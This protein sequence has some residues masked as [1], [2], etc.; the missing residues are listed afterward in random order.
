MLFGEKT[1]KLSTINSKC[2][3]WDN[4]LFRCLLPKFEFQKTPKIMPQKMYIYKAAPYIRRTKERGGSI[5]AIQLQGQIVQHTF[6]SFSCHSCII[7]I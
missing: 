5:K 3:I 7:D 2:Y 6:C 4:L 1:L